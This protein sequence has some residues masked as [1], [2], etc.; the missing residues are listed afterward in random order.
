MH[1]AKLVTNKFISIN[2]KIYLAGERKT[3]KNKNPDMAGVIYDRPRIEWRYS[4]P[5]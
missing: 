1:K 5:N 4:F 2:V 3:T